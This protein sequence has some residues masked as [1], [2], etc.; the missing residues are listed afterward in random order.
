MSTRDLKL[1]PNLLCIVPPYPLTSVPLGPAALLGYLK[2]NG[3]HDFDFLDLRLWVPYG[4][5]PTQSHLGAFGDTFVLDVPELPLV[6]EMLSAYEQG[7]PLVG[8][9]SSLFERYCAER[10]INSVYLHGYLTML[11]RFFEHTFAQMKD[12]RFVG[13][14]CWTTNYLATMMAAAHLKRRKSPP[15]IV[16]GGPQVT[17]SVNSGKLGLASGLFDAVA[18]GEGEETLLSLY[19]AFCQGGGR[20]SVAVPGTMQRDGDGGFRV[21]DR[22]ALRM[23]ELPLPSFDEMMISSY[24]RPYDDPKYNHLRILPFQLSRGCTDKCSFCSEWVFWR[25]Y[26]VGPVDRAVEQLK[27]L[28]ARYNVDGIWFADSLLNGKL[29]RLVEF[30]EATKKGGLEVL[31]GGYMRAD[32]SRDVA[33]LAFEAGCRNVFLGVESMDDETLEM[34][35][36]RRSEAQN[37]QALRAFLET[38]MVVQAGLIAGF[39]GDTR[40]RFM[41]TAQILQKLQQEYPNL[42]VNTEAFNVMPGQPIFQDLTRYGLHPK[43]WDEEY[44]DIAP[45]YRPLTEAIFCSV[46]GP[47]QGI[48]RLGE[49]RIGDSLAY[50]TGKPPSLDIEPYTAFRFEQKHLRG[51][52]SLATLK[53][54]SA[55]IY[56]VIL[57]AEE[58]EEL[59]T[60][61]LMDTV[62]GQGP[63]PLLENPI[64]GELVERV[65]R[66]HLVRPRRT[67]PGVY[68]A[69]YDTRLAEDATFALSPF[70]IARASE[71]AGELLVVN[72]ASSNLTVLPLGARWLVE[73]F[74]EGPRFLSE[75]RVRAAAVQAPQAEAEWMALLDELREDGLLVVNDLRAQGPK[76]PFVRRTS[77]PVVQSSG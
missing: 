67:A 72:I 27:E 6:L 60:G 7:R 1:K 42:A 70:V 41:H 17:E 36:K 61:Y 45:A 69:C 2:A 12:L 54:P 68:T 20:V 24:G 13:L 35:R 11:D 77:L 43:G 4:S 48:D 21:T 10:V 59:E 44:L 65:E 25:T 47:N 66:A 40:S 32:M 29:S 75:V 51:D 76:A 53:S 71:G 28:K 22:K 58:R 33:S 30:C 46:D 39:P 38:G 14:S 31:W 57:N 50:A 73:L 15:F 37:I 55:L 3:C 8:P 9:P 26:R 5:A 18:L 52:L 19:E 49:F 62:Q 34:M 56:A 64:F 74:A 23:R 16:V 63:R